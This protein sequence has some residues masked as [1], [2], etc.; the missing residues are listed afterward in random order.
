VGEV[1]VWAT[2]DDPQTSSAAAQRSASPAAG[3]FDASGALP[4]ATSGAAREGSAADGQLTAQL[5]VYLRGARTGEWIEISDGV[6]DITLDLNG[7]AERRVGVRFL[8]SGRY[9]GCRVV[10]TRVEANVTGGLIVGGVPILGLVR[11][12]LGTQGTLT[13]ERGLVL[14]VE[15]RREQDIV[16]DLAANTWLPRLSLTTRTVAAA[17]LRDAVGVRVR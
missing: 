7:Q 16:L 9:S 5:R 13:V 15:A 14:D 2:A 3:A 10:F 11:V 8:D 17:A 4:S 6:R 1:E 12:D